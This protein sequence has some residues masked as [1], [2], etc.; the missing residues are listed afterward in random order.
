MMSFI[1]HPDYILG[2]KPQTIYRE[3]LSY[4]TELRSKAGVWIALPGEVN[5]WWRQ[6]SEMKLTSADGIW[7]VVGEGRER[8]RV[9][10]A[11]IRNDRIAYTVAPSYQASQV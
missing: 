6:R 2:K 7:Q 5:R 10:F 8:A 11:H 3:L 9:A 4:L 1:V